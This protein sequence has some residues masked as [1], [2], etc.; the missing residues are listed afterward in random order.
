MEVKHISINGTSYDLIAKT[1]F[2]TCTL[3]TFSAAGSKTIECVGVTSDSHPTLDVYIDAAANVD[4]C[5][6]AWSHIYK[7]I[8]GN[9]TL[10]FYSNDATSTALT[11]LVKDY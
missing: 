9:G 7:V 2:T 1:T 3:P 10:I 11:I 5:R 8:S 4:A 6:D